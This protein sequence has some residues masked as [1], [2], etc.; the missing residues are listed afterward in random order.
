MDKMTRRKALGGFAALATTALLPRRA[1]AGLQCKDFPGGRV[2]E[3]GVPSVAMVTAS[4]QETQWCWAASIQ[5]VLGYHGHEVDQKTIVTK[6][7]GSAANMPAQ[8]GTILK[9]LNRTWTDK[10]GD[11]FRVGAAPV[12]AG[13]V[14]MAHELAAGFPLIIGYSNG[15][16]GHA[17]VLTAMSY[18]ALWGRDPW[19]R[20][21]LGP[22]TIQQVEVRDPWDGKHRLLK[23]GEWG[24]IMFA[25]KVRVTS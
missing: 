7:Y 3:A 2:C 6:A 21:V 14:E 4:Q 23:A 1:E 24:S 12:G 17:V 8:P 22:A 9:E 13:A 25:A 19:G 18:S 10:G 16:Q 20:P 15:I 5:M 11:R